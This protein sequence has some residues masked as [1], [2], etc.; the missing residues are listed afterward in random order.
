MPRRDQDTIISRHI[1]R[2]LY[3]LLSSDASPDE[4]A[5]RHHFL[6]WLTGDP[7]AYSKHAAPVVAPLFRYVATHR[8]ALRREL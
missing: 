7:R 6:G 3:G 1:R 4:A 8:D 5:R 2:E